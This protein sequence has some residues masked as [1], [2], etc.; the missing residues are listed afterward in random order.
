MLPAHERSVNRRELAP[1]NSRRPTIEDN[2]MCRPEQDVVRI[3]EP[4][5]HPPDRESVLEIERWRQFLRR[6]TSGLGL[7]LVFRQTAQIDEGGG[8]LRCC[9]HAAGRPAVVRRKAGAEHFVPPQ[10][11]CQ[12]ATHRGNVEPPDQP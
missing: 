12:R 4:Q 2:M 3:A 10:L 11:L 8:S 6:Q 1:Q 7:P 9:Q 5:Q